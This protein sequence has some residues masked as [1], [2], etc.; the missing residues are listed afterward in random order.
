MASLGKRWGLSISALTPA[1]GRTVERICLSGQAEASVHHCAAS[2]LRSILSAWPQRIPHIPCDPLCISV[3]GPASKLPLWAPSPNPVDCSTNPPSHTHGRPASCVGMHPDRLRNCP[4]RIS[5]QAPLIAVPRRGPL[6]R[7]C[8]V[9]CV[10]SATGRSRKQH[11]QP[12]SSPQSTVRLTMHSSCC[13][14]PRSSDDS[15]DQKSGRFS[16]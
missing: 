4:F 2:D 14:P 7:G 11:P 16:Y 10:S 9:G 5:L 3:R 6:R 1:T 15:Y 13:E 8:F 12:K